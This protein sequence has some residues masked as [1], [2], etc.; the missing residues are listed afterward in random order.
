MLGPPINKLTLLKTAASVLNFKLWPHLRNAR[1][2]L[3]DCS[4]A[5]SV[6]FS[7]FTEFMSSSNRGVAGK[8]IRGTEPHLDNGE[9]PVSISPK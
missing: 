4:A 2:P 7:D 3:V 9:S 1:P 8:K 6:E 5:G